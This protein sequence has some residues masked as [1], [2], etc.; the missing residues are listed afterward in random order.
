MN[1]KTIPF[2]RIST[3]KQ[4]EDIV[5]DRAMVASTVSP[6]LE[7]SPGEGPWRM[8]GIKLTHLQVA[9]SLPCSATR[10]MPRRL[11]RFE[12]TSGA[13]ATDTVVRAPEMVQPDRTT[14]AH[15]RVRARSRKN[16][17]I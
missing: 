10:R 1:H 11:A 16:R 13:L 4:P 14:R 2:G 17:T 12:E 5:G 15:R 7:R 8:R 9:A 3:S 6:R